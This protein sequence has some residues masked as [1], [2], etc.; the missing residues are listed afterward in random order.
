MVRA[1]DEPLDSGGAGPLCRELSGPAMNDCA[2]RYV[3]WVSDAVN[4]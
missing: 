2:G 1:G 3:V 4:Q